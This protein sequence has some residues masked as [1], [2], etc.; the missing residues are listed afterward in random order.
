[1]EKP[2]GEG[3]QLPSS[4]CEL[5][6]QALD[7]LSNEGDNS[8]QDESISEEEERSGYE[9]ERSLAGHYLARFTRFDGEEF[10]AGFQVIA[11]TLPELLG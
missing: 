1:M 2:G 7:P 8:G 4:S 3:S 6:G 9:S 10:S 11:K 5:S